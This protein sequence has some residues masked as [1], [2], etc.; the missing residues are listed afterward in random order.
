VQNGV[1]MHDFFTNAILK[2][3][4]CGMKTNWHAQYIVACNIKH[5]SLIRQFSLM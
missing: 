5:V 1:L 4:L 2:L 3:M